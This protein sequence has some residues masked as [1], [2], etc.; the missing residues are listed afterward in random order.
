M[1]N[2][3]A[4]KGLRFA[5]GHEGLEVWLQNKKQGAMKGLRFANGH[6]GLQDEAGTLF[7]AASKISAIAS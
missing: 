3:G 2:Q 4:M 5:N 1:H 6:E 7:Q